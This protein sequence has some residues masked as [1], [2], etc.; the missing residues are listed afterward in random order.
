MKYI[1]ILGILFSIVSC[2]GICEPDAIEDID[3]CESIQ[4]SEL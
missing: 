2:N 1:V 4:G 3:W